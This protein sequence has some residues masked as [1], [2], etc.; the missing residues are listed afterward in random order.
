MPFATIIVPTYNQAHF[1]GAAL[2]S[3]LAQTDTD[4][5]AIV[6]NDGSTDDTAKVLDTYAARDDRIRAIHQVNGGVGAALNRGLT[7]ARGEWIHWCS[8]DDLFE[9]EKL[10]INRRWIALHPQAEFFYSLFRLL[11]HSSGVLE[12]RDLWGPRPAEHLEVLGLLYRNFISGI[13][14]CVRKESWIRVGLFNP[15]LRYGQDYDMWLRLLVALKPCFIPERTVIS[16]NHDAQGSEIFPAACYYDSARAALGLLNRHSFPELVPWADLEQPDQA[17]AAFEQAMASAA[18][19]TS[20]VYRLGPHP[21]LAG[22]LLEWLWGVEATPWIEDLR[23][24]FQ[25][26]ADELAVRHVHTDFGKMWATVSYSAAAGDRRVVPTDAAALAVQRIARI[27][28]MKSAET[29]DLQRYIAGF[30]CPPAADAGHYPATVLLLAPPQSLDTVALATALTLRGHLV[31]RIADALG[32]DAAGLCITPLSNESDAS[33]LL[34]HLGPFDLV[35]SAGTEHAH[36]YSIADQHLSI[37]ADAPGLLAAI[38]QKLPRVAAP[39]DPR[40]TVV[41]FNY[42]DQG[43]GAERVLEQLCRC[44]DRSRYIVEVLTL[45]RSGLPSAFPSA[46]R[47]RCI[48]DGADEITSSH[49]LEAVSVPAAAPARELVDLVADRVSPTLRAHVRRLG[50]NRV[51]VPLLRAVASVGRGPERVAR[52]GFRAYRRLQSTIARSTD[53]IANA[54]LH[55]VATSADSALADSSLGRR[56]REVLE[57]L[58][59]DALIVTFMEHAVLYLAAVAPERLPNVVASFH[60]HESTYLPIIFSDLHTLRDVEGVFAEVAREARACTFPSAGCAD[61]FRQHYAPRSTNVHVIENPVDAGMVRFL[62]GAERDTEICQWIGARPLLV[63]VARLD[64]EKNHEALLVAVASLVQRGFDLAVLCIG[65]GQIKELLETRSNEL[66]L[67]AHVRFTGGLDNPF[68]WLARARA[69]ALTSRFEAFALVLVEA[70][71]LGVPVVAVDCPSGPREVLRNGERGLLIPQND[72]E[73]LAAAILRV[74]TDQALRTQLG[75]NAESALDEY[76]PSEYIR[77]LTSFL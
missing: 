47:F 9:P 44:L 62:A 20:F 27:G 58:P 54:K 2:D 57:T 19:P 38:E 16:R 49:Q 67:H 18:D 11:R 29:L 13:S 8:S 48:S 40:R 51:V 4:W 56:V 71:A 39:E 70:M 65:A 23:E 77:K 75:R 46:T 26:R 24:R 52:A 7:A 14:I 64:Q 53:V 1:L 3:L 61:D 68:P 59:A 55:A 76:H 10:S 60:T 15:A 73:A 36:R 42:T 6:V 12:E 69:L 25:Q 41:L 66:G 45:Y 21:A 5:E 37:A 28:A 32:A 74:M 35:V 72:S 17:M 30:A 63:S 33:R 50:I 34:P 31:V 43:G 22:R